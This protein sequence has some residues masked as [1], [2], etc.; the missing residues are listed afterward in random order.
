MLKDPSMWSQ[1]RYSPRLVADWQKRVQGFNTK[2]SP[3]DR[4]L[5]G[6]TLDEESRS[7][8]ADLMLHMRPS[9][10]SSVSRAQSIQD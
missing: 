8:T 6:K 10:D 2:A 5:H 3:F 7:S 9:I 1:P 4:N